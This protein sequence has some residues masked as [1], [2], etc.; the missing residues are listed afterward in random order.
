MRDGKGGEGSGTQAEAAPQPLRTLPALHGAESCPGPRG[1]CSPLE[2]PR[3]PASRAAALRYDGDGAGIG[4]VAPAGAPAPVCGAARNA[5]T[6]GE[7][8]GRTRSLQGWGLG[9][10]GLGRVAATGEPRPLTPTGVAPNRYLA[11]FGE[12]PVALTNTCWR[13][14]PAWEGA[15]TRTPGCRSSVGAQVKRTAK[16]RGPGSTPMPSIAS[17]IPAS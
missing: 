6:T 4:P 13:E 10:R 5:G 14:V 3:D 8:R 11:S 7:K 12:L 1:P 16:G 9:R 15:G 2:A 17:R